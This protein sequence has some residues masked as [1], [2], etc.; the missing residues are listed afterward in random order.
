[1]GAFFC[2]P[3][4]NTPA[5]ARIIEDFVFKIPIMG[6][7]RKQI[8]FAEYARTM[9]LLITAGISILDA[10]RIV[11]DA[12]DSKLI[13]DSIRETA[14]KVEKGQPLSVVL[15]TREDYPPIIA[16]M[17]SVGEQTGKVD[18]I[19]GRLADYFEGESEVAVKALTTAIEPL[20]MVVMGLG[21]GFLVMAV[22]MPIYSLTSQF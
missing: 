15:S 19:L 13:G 1:M 20:I 4:L 22:I 11:A 10:M 6:P 8:V 14:L 7:L 12:V 3:C 17:L 21:V 5:A 16:Q 2:S 9:S 18:E